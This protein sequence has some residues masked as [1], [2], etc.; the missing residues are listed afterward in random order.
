MQDV[1]EKIK[2][3]NDKICKCY[4]DHKSTWIILQMQK[5]L[6]RYVR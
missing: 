6:K 3:I 5:N 4:S 1:V 2:S